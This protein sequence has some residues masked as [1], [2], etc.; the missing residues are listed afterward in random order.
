MTTFALLNEPGCLDLGRFA[1]PPPEEA[2]G[3][4]ATSSGWEGLRSGRGTATFRTRAVRECLD[5]VAVL[6]AYREPL[7]G[8]VW[9]LPWASERR[10]LS[11]VN[12]I[13]A[14][15]RESLGQVVDLAIDPDLP[16]PGRVFAALFV[17]GC[18]AGPAWLQPTVRIFV[19]AVER[20]PAERAAAVEALSLTQNGEVLEQVTELL[21]HERANVRA[22]AVRVLSFRSGLR[23]SQWTRAI[24]DDDAAVAQ[25]AVCAP[26]IDRDLE[27]CRRALE[28]LLHHRSE[29]VVRSAL[30]AGLTL[31]LE[32]AHFRAREMSR[33]SP[34]WADALH[35]LAMFGLA[36]DEDT[37]RTALTGA[38]WLSGVRAVALSGR[39]GLIPDLVALAPPGDVTPAQRAEI[40]LA[41]TTITDL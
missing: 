1:L 29:G 9:S 32:V 14:F 20:C 23:Q 17:L 37:L 18:V 31:R 38:Q 24:E 13:L 26:V 39:G 6:R 5:T 10:L 21:T 4:D 15:G 33:K 22:A 34:E 12:V 11:Q 3:L 40:A 41:L 7:P 16:D 35:F 25:A 30:R 27:G 8:E 28:H 19:T 2:P 36:S